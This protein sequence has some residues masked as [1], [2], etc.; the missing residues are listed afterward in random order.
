MKNENT[1]RNALYAGAFLQVV[2]AGELGVPVSAVSY[3]YG[4]QGKPEL[5]MERIG[6]EFDGEDLK[7]LYFNLSHSG[8]Y[9]VL[10]VSDET[11]GI[12]IEY[13]NK[14][15]LRIAERFFCPEEYDV[16]AAADSEKER[17]QLFLQYWT[18]K[19]AYVKYCGTGLQLPLSSFLIRRNRN[20]GIF[21]IPNTEIWFST[22][23]LDGG[24]HCV[25]ICSG[26]KSGPEKI[27]TSISKIDVKKLSDR[28]LWNL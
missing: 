1:A 6:N 11:V 12:D 28:G 26:E 14:N 7:R 8:D 10:A 22:F 19:E 17:K 5:D 4:E 27:A 3:I 9:V 24:N 20:T 15:A 13:K 21:W 23:F 2:L 25:S 18:M 16:I